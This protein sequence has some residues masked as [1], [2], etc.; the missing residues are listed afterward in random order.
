MSEEEFSKL[1]SIK[2]C[3]VCG[4]EL[5]KGYIHAGRGIYWDVERHKFYSIPGE[6]ILSMWS[7]TNPY[8]PALRCCKCKIL[9]AHYGKIEREN[10]P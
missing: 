7:L 6:A 8:A 4:G 2:E 10:V 9:I 1:D 3:P 5:E